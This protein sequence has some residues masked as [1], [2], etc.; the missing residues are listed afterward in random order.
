MVT[1][2]QIESVGYILIC[3]DNLQYEQIRKPSVALGSERDGFTSGITA[4]L[5]MCFS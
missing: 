5:R 2:M 3:P 1:K 4:M